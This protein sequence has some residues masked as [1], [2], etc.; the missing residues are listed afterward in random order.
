MPTTP[1]ILVF[2][3]EDRILLLS[4]LSSYARDLITLWAKGDKPL[5]ELAEKTLNQLI[6][7]AEPFSE[8]MTVF[9]AT[10][11]KDSLVTVFR[12]DGSTIQVTPFD[13][14]SMSIRFKTIDDESA[15]RSKERHTP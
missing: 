6:I 5:Q 13:Y 4:A 10:A 8:Q 1:N 15:I 2:S 14:W 3:G 9:V 12:E 7:V 11:F